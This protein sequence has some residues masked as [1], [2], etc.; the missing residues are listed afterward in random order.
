VAKWSNTAVFLA[1][2]MIAGISPNSQL[3]IIIWK[4]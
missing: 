2:R 1:R 3:H 4:S